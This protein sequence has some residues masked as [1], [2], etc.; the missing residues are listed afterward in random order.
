MRHHVFRSFWHGGPLSPV[1]VLC[2]NSF[3]KQGHNFELFSYESLDVPDGTRLLDAREILPEDRIFKCR[4]GTYSAFSDLFRYKM[5]YVRGGWWVDCDVIC[6]S[7]NI[8]HK[9]MVFARQ[10][11]VDQGNLINNAILRIPKGHQLTARLVASAERAGPDLPW[12]EIGP[13]LLTKTVAE[14]GLE[15][16][17]LR[18]EL[19]YPLFWPEALVLYDPARR[20][21]LENRIVDSMFV[22]LWNEVLRLNCVDKWTRPA[23]GSFICSMFDKFAPEVWEKNY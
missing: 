15:H 18:S 17:A 19:L 22:H 7:S 10:G 6:I 9:K 12:G 5:L 14:L 23:H 8:T 1:E 2:I 11:G 21:Y 4:R 16:C 13:Q 20:Q 3:L